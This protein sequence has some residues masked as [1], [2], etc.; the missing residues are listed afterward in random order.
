MSTAGYNKN[1]FNPPETLARTAHS[2]SIL[3]NGVRLGLIQ[4]WNPQQS[5]DVTP[6]YELNVET[7]GLP[8]ENIPGNVR[9]LTIGI[10]RY[11]LW[12]QRM[13]QVF[14]TFDLSMLSNQQS[15]F[16]VVEEWSKPDGTKETWEYSGCW[17]TNIGRSLKSDDNRIVQVS[18]SLT[19]VYKRKLS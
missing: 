3:Y 8:L 19:Y 15:P 7:S 2:L 14:G 12:T 18:A 5:R 11:D 17:F 10:T 16:S 4:G 13:E 9:G 1:P 6:I